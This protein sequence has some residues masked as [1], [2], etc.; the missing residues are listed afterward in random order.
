MQ[1][2]VQLKGSEPEWRNPEN[3]FFYFMKP[4]CSKGGCG[5]TG[6]VYMSFY[7]FLGSMEC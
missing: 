6:H 5:L 2:K 7:T 3:Y 4:Q 1:I